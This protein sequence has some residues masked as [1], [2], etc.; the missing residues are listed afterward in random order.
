MQKKLACYLCKKRNV[1]IAFKKLGYKFFKCLN[2]HL[3]WL[4]FK[5]SYSR[6]IQKYYQEGYFKGD[7]KY[8]AYA[9]YEDD[10]K[11]IQKNMQKYL[12]KIRNFKSSGNLLDIGCALGFFIEICQKNGFNSYGLDISKYAVNIANKIAPNRAILGSIAKN[13]F[14]NILFDVITMF[15]LIEHLKDPRKDLAKIHTMLKD[16]GILVIQTGDS[17]S[18]WT[19][20]VDKC[21]HFFAPPQHLFFFNKKNIT[22]ILKQSGFEVIKIEKDGK[23]VSLR[24]LFYMMG[25]TQNSDI[26]DCLYGFI[27]NNFLGKI[28]LYFRFNDNIIVYAK[29][30]SF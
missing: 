2:C 10:K 18:L 23:W 20:I 24:Y 15:D 5:D 14:K 27:K 25:Y 8:R 1:D 30:T 9:D 19:K 12:E 16:N 4:E 22:E 13:G 7:K 29:K 26:S 21:W 3:Y 6:F 17:G 28:P 11:I